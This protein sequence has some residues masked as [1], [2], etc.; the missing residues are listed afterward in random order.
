LKRV[1]GYYLKVKEG[2]MLYGMMRREWGQKVRFWPT[3]GSDWHFVAGLAFLGKI[4]SLDF[5]GYNKEAG[6]YF[7]H[8]SQL[9]Q[10]VWRE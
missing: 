9:C 1:L 4:K 10:G 2:A 8:F 6:W 7:P 3:I 5:V